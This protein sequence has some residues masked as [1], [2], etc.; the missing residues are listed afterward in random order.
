MWFRAIATAAILLFVGTPSAF[1][2]L[3]DGAAVLRAMATNDDQLAVGGVTF[4][5][6]KITLPVGRART[7]DPA[8]R[9]KWKFTCVSANKIAYDQEVVEVLKW[10]DWLPAGRSIPQP[11][12]TTFMHMRLLSFLSPEATGHYDFIGPP[13]FEPGV[14]STRPKKV[15]DNVSMGSL[16][17]HAPNPLTY[18]DYLDLPLLLV[19]R[20]YARHIESISSVESLADGRLSVKAEGKP[21]YARATQWELIVEPAAAYLVRSA[22]YYV[23]DSDRTIK[24][25]RYVITTSGL[26]WFGSLAV[27]EKFE[28]RDPFLDKEQPF[29]KSGTV[30]SASL[31]GD[32][33]FFK[34]TVATFQAPFPVSTDSADLRTNP[35]LR[36]TFPAGEVLDINSLRR[37]NRMQR[38]PRS[39]L[40]SMPGVSAAGSRIR[41]VGRRTGYENDEDSSFVAVQPAHR[42]VGRDA[43]GADGQATAL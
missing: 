20:G 27:P 21:F 5:G 40:G 11:D 17:L 14:W 43:G 8:A 32:E 34:E 28:Q 19:G 10:E 13:R 22:T 33:P 18:L 2:A 39:R 24:K 9:W 29:H 4:E 41:V 1:A 3:P 12:K 16:T 42:P 38:S 36:L 26:R 15:H 31:K 25:P 23:D 35:P 37:T 30:I 6:T 7:C